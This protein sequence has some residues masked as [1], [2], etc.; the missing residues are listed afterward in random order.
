MCEFAVYVRWERSERGFTTEDW[1]LRSWARD[2]KV[3]VTQV[4]WEIEPDNPVKNYRVVEFK[5]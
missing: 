4:G 3:R 5:I 2:F 1:S